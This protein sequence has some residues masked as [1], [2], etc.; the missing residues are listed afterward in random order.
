MSSK[1]PPFTIVEA[2]VFEGA[3]LFETDFGLE[4]D[5]KERIQTVLKV[6]KQ[7]LVI[8]YYCIVSTKTMVTHRVKLSIHERDILK[9]WLQSGVHESRITMELKYPFECFSGIQPWDKQKKQRS[10]CEWKDADDEW[11]QK[12]KANRFVAFSVRGD[13]KKFAKALK[14]LHTKWCSLINLR[15]DSLQLPKIEKK[16]EKK[17]EPRDSKAVEKDSKKRGVE[18]EADSK[19]KLK[20]E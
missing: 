1:D 5:P 9:I 11:A 17:K 16:E 6:I 13:G 3:S 15:V 18:D 4:P 2:L 10:V 20:S 8:E 12:V 19:K 7:T 14:Q